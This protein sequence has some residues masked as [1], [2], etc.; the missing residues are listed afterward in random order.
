M[1][2]FLGDSPASEL[3]VP[4]FRNTVSAIFIGGEME[5]RVPKR[6][7]ITFRSRGITQKKEYNVQNKAKVLKQEV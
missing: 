4:T 1:Y 6:R 2:S 3:Y 5:Q 7:H